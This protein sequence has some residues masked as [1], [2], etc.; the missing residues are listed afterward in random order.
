[1][2][3]PDLHRGIPRPVRMER[4][5][6][7]AP[8][9]SL[10]EVLV[11]VAASGVMELDQPPG[12][13][14]APGEAGRIVRH[15]PA[16]PDRRALSERPPDVAGLARAGRYDLL[17]G[18]AQLEDY[19]AAAVRR[20]STA[21]L[22]GWVPADQVP[23]LEARLRK[24]GGAA[25]RLRRPP[26]A[27]PP[28]LVGGAAAKRSFEGFM[29]IYGTV[30]Y[31]DL[32]PAPLAWASYVLIFGMMFG[33]VGHGLALIAIAVCMWARRPR[34]LARVRPAWPFVAGAGAA[35]AVFGL[36]YGECFGPSGVVPVLWL[37]PLDQ[38][39]TLL[40]VALAAGVVLL[41]GA[42]AMGVAN[43][44]REGGGAAALYAPTGLAGVAVFLG[45]GAAAG[46]LY[47]RLYVLLGVGAA[48]A[49]AG[50]ALVF[51]GFLAE[52]GGGGAGVAE[53]S[54]ELFDLVIRLGSNVVS[55]ARLAAFGLTHAAIGLVVWEATA[56]LWHR[57]GAGLALAI[58][59]FAVGNALAFSLEALVAGIQAMRLEYYELFSRVFVTQGHPFRP[60]HLPVCP[61]ESKEDVPCPAG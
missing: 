27:E 46:G 57:G 58:V 55:F 29:E 42:Y 49:A 13:Q 45:I 17:A 61:E 34:W 56:S 53:A 7:V 35:S 6:V 38:P 16:A 60:W 23:A 2:Q 37:R 54:V 5:A 12:R 44:W 22:A 48:A 43:R 51:A 39:L 50:L 1:M 11:R 36:L 10:R 24:V 25:M 59:V 52:A 26:G 31:A 18:E 9:A 32:D 8:A 21:A 47:L 19:A 3:A 33:D 28:T 40:A 20:G 15:A 4:I 14:A 41:A 30:P